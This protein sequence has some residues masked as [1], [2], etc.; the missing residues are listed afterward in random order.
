MKNY[1][2]KQPSRGKHYAYFNA[3][4][5]KRETDDCVIRA[6]AIA[7]DLTW[8]DIY[9]ALEKIGRD[10]ATV[11]DS[12]DCWKAFIQKQNVEP[13][14]TIHKG[15][16]RRKRGLDFAKEHADGR[17][18]LNMAGHLSVCVDGCI[19]DI[20]DCSDSMVYKAWKVNE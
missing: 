15:D 17:Y 12:D 13:I 3:N 7:F 14:Q 16:R 1:E 4:P 5:K 18:V 19:Y 20:F 11:Q 6:L 10:N 9:D 2:L 8:Y